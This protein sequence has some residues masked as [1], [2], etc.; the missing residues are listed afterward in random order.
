M[1]PKEEADR[2]VKDIHKLIS[3]NQDSEEKAVKISI[4]FAN[5]I[6]DQYENKFKKITKSEIV[7]RLVLTT[8]WNQVKTQLNKKLKA[9]THEEV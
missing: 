4:L 8:H 6:L 9:Y 7:A 2:L 3:D 1:S 5:E